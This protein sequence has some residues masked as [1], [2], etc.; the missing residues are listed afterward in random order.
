M[1]GATADIDDAG[2]ASRCFRALRELSATP[3]LLL[4]YHDRSDGGADG[5]VLEMAFAGHCGL[6]IGVRCGSGSAIAHL[7]AEEPGAVLQVG[8]A[9]VAAV[10]EVWPSTAWRHRGS[11]GRPRTGEADASVAGGRRVHARSAL[12]DMR[13]A[14]SRDFVPDAAA[15]RRSGCA[16]EEFAAQLDDADPGLQRG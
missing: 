15:A 12:G 10:L 1:G 6:D 5:H 9:I 2:A 4:A 8:G 3:A 14:W 13:R 11:V 16:A 7:F